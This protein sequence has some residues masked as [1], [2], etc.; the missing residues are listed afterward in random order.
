MN[1][2]II[3]QSYVS[4]GLYDTFDPRVTLSVVENVLRLAKKKGMRNP[5][6]LKILDVGA[7][8]GNFAFAIEK[9]VNKVVAIE[10][11]NL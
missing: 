4:A 3:D 9:Y 10:P 11:D 1:K 5:K 8:D 6:K 7:G 2:I